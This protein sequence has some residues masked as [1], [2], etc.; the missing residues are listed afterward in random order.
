MAE[1]ENKGGLVPAHVADLR[2]AVAGTSGGT[3]DVLLEDS[4]SVRQ[5]ADSPSEFCIVDRMVGHAGKSTRS[6]CSPAVR[7]MQCH[8]DMHKSRH[9]SGHLG[10]QR[11][12]SDPWPWSHD[13]PDWR[14]VRHTPAR[15]WSRYWRGR[16][17]GALSGLQDQ[18][19]HL[20]QSQGP[21]QKE[22]W[23]AGF[24]QRSKAWLYVDPSHDETATNILAD[25]YMDLP[26]EVDGSS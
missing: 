12:W 21:R 17:W 3:K 5:S 20:R 18:L 22:A 24:V 15:A 26:V 14:T 9:C 25:I 10:S 2:E 19:W 13:R 7:I 23:T 11:N 8:W 4:G 1:Q 6:R 16:H